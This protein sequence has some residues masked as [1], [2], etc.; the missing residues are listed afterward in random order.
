[1]F[2]KNSNS[3]SNLATH[4]MY[5]MLEPS[6]ENFQFVKYR[7]MGDLL[8]AQTISLQKPAAVPKQ[9]TAK[10][11]HNTINESSFEKL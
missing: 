9:S 2:S 1:M 11:V 6:L 5:R 3:S 10:I 4:N 8:L 7:K